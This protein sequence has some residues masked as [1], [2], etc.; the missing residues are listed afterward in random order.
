M[1]EPFIRDYRLS[2]LGDRALVIELG[3]DA[4]EQTALKVRC[5]SE[6]LLADALTGVLDVV[7]AVCTAGLRGFGFA[8]AGASTVTAGSSPGLLWAKTPLDEASS[9]A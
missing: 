9:A 2:P 1:A 7:P 3:D 8:V 6:R 4:S 5:V